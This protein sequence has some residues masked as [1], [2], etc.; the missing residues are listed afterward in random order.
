MFDGLPY[1]V[2]YVWYMLSDG[3][4][5][6]YIMNQNNYCNVANEKKKKAITMYQLD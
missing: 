6:M 1:S 5:M 3:V 4:L 2:Y